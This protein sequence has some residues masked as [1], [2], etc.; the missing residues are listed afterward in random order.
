MMLN[1][2]SKKV[3][4]P[5]SSLPTE[6]ERERVSERVKRMKTVNP[7]WLDVGNI[8]VTYMALLSQPSKT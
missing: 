1:D 5:S 7:V 2:D 4:M 6:R 8:S 3:I